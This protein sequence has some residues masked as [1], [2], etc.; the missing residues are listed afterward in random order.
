MKQRLGM[1]RLL[2]HDMKTQQASLQDLLVA[3]QPHTTFHIPLYQRAFVWQSVSSKSALNGRAMGPLIDFWQDLLDRVWREETEHFFGTII[4][5]RKVGEIGATT[6]EIVDGQQRLISFELLLRISC[7]LMESHG[8]ESELCESLQEFGESCP[9]LPS[10]D[11]EDSVVLEAIRE[12]H[13]H[14]LPDETRSSNHIAIAYGF[15]EKQIKEDLNSFEELEELVERVLS[16]SWFIVATLDERDNGETIF[17]VINSRG[18]P[19]AASDMVKNLLLGLG[20]HNASV[21]GRAEAL[22]NDLASAFPKTT[23]RESCLRAIATRHAEI[24]YSLGLYELLRGVVATAKEE[25]HVNSW[26][27]GSRLAVDVYKDIC[28]PRANQGQLEAFLRLEVVGGPLDRLLVRLVELD[29]ADSPLLGLLENLIV[30]FYICRPSLAPHLKRIA[31]KGCGFLGGKRLSIT[32]RDEL[33]E[34]L[35]AE[36]W[37]H[38]LDDAA[39]ATCFAEK[40]LYRGKRSRL[41]YMLEKIENSLNPKQPVR[42]VLDNEC[43]IEHVMPQKLTAEWRTELAR[44]AE[45]F[46]ALKALHGEWLHTI[47]NL[48]ILTGPVNASIGNKAYALKRKYYLDPNNRDVRKEL[49]IDQ[50]GSATTCVLNQYFEAHTHWTFPKIK[51]RGMALAERASQIWAIDGRSR[52]PGVEEKPECGRGANAD[53]VVLAP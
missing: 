28:E 38:A 43:Q 11:S 6:L 27:Y 48:T 22:W 4:L 13:L 16:Q 46:E 36:C 12:G 8:W 51:K 2:D 9:I 35:V 47:G 30:R 42:M 24:D 49:G 10:E 31:N 19:M 41:L 26:I 23:E 21:K 29:G 5:Q 32:W 17:E 15:L 3:S 7:K 39:F 37:E 40:K 45:G 20:E 53:S 33:K 14:R 52:K 44:N 18:M 1:F 34:L 50:D 25:D